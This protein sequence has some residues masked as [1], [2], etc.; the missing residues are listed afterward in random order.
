[1]KRKDA[2]R[3]MYRTAKVMGLPE[4][5]V[6]IR[7]EITHGELPSLIVLRKYAARALNWLWEHYWRRLT[8]ERP[9]L[10]KSTLA[11]DGGEEHLKDCLRV[12]LRQFRD[13]RIQLARKKPN[14]FKQICNNKSTETTT[15]GLA[16]FKICRNDSEALKVLSK[17]FLEG[18]FLVPSNRRLVY[19]ILCACYYAHLL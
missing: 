12:T 18:K 4:A 2:R 7:H 14:A 10:L 15:T 9:G 11:F 1:M 13:P 3:S 19:H 8:V 5:F 6:E 16:L 17:V